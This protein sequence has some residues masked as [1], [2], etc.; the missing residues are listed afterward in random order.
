M[1]LDSNQKSLCNKLV[2]D[3]DVLIQPGKSAKSLMD[4]T[5]N[6]MKSKLSGMTFS[7]Q[8]Q[9]NAA[10]EAYRS[11]VSDN[12]PKGDSIEDLNKIKDFI[13]GC[14]YLKD[15]N[16]ISAVIGTIGG[17]IDTVN[18]LVDNFDLTIPEFGAGGFGSLI[19]KLLDGIPGIPGNDKIS[20]LLALADKLL[21][22]LSNSC[23]AFDPS[24]VGDLS[25]MT[26]ELQDTYDFLGLI[27][28]PNDPNYGKFDYSAMYNDVGLTTDEVAAINK[29]KDGINA[30]KDAGS[31]AVNNTV[32]AMKN[33]IKGGLF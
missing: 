4:S 9:L 6:D 5:I 8:S 26:Q 3:F 13:D 16:P 22:C 2:S 19:D 18:G 10:L 7:S 25:N 1:A 30:A 21:D 15:L 27:D 29:T 20:D 14:D 31:E 28:N 33:A 11:Q 24:Y 32:S 17:V 12:L 23:A